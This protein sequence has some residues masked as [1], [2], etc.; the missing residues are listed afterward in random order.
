MPTLNNHV[1][2]KQHQGAGVADGVPLAPLGGSTRPWQLDGVWA[3][4]GLAES[5][6]LFP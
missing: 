6:G 4:V 3:L 1:S 5:D 2:E